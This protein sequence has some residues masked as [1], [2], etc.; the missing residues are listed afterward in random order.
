MQHLFEWDK[1]I[2]GSGAELK[3]G[4]GQPWKIKDSGICICCLQIDLTIH[5]F[6]QTQHSELFIK[7]Y[8]LLF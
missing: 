3:G 1:N 4:H 5:N 7:Y 2:E 6:D 8:G